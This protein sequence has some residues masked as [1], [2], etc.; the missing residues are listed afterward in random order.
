MIE[1]AAETLAEQ[2]MTAAAMS[3]ETPSALGLFVTEQAV[4]IVYREGNESSGRL[5]PYT[6]GLP[7]VTALYNET[8]PEKHQELTAKILSFLGNTGSLQSWLGGLES[9]VYRGKM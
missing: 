5:F 6:V 4:E 1:G 8:E 9:P 7:F 3:E 2:A